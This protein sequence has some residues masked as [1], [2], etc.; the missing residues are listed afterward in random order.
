MGRSDV[1]AAGGGHENA[2]AGLGRGQVAPKDTVK[3]S[4]LASYLRSDD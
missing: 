1:M 4:R 2:G 3:V